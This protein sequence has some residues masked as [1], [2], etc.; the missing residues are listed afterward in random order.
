MDLSH[1]FGY[2]LFKGRIKV[3]SDWKGHGRKQSQSSLGY[4]SRLSLERLR[5]TTKALKQDSWYSR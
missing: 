3:N 5:K 4:Y 2:I 1:I